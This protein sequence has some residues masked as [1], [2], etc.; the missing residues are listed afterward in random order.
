MG[1]KKKQQEP[2]QPFSVRL[3]SFEAEMLKTKA[4]TSNMSVSKYMRTMILNGGVADGTAHE[5]RMKLT[6]ELAAVGNNV[7]Q[8]V[9]LANINGVITEQEIQKIWSYLREMNR[10]IIESVYGNH[11]G[12]L[13]NEQPPSVAKL[14]SEKVADIVLLEDRS[15]I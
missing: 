14:S 2:R 7:N 15:V 9:R 8:A 1:R 6:H 13:S 11:A 4:E 5:D 10:M 12:I 3:S